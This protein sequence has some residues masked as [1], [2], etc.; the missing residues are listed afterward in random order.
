MLVLKDLFF[1]I[2]DFVDVIETLLFYRIDLPIALEIFGERISYIQLWQIL[3]SVLFIAIFILW[4][5]K[6]VL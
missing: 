3:G 2:I 1:K 5:R 4:F 6:K